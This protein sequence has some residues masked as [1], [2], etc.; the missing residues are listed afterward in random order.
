MLI[1]NEDGPTVALDKDFVD[2][3]YK[4][5]DPP[6][7]KPGQILEGPIDY[8]HSTTETIEAEARRI[9]GGERNSDYGSAKD[10][11]SNTALIWTGILRARF[12]NCNLHLDAQTVALMMAAFKLCREAN[13]GKRDNRVDAI[14]YL[15]LE[16]QILGSP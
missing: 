1:S 15:L 2:K 8:Q 7:Y 10:N 6:A 4:P 5:Y 14:G 11:F 9:I 3:E 16:D 12:K 13:K